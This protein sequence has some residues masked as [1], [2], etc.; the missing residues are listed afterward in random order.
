[1]Q[2]PGAEEKMSTTVTPQ[3]EQFTLDTAHTSVEFVVRHLMISKVRGRFTDPA[4]TIDVPAGSDLPESLQV[5]IDAAG[6]DTREPQRDD[7]LR[8]ADFFDTAKYP[9]I[10]YSSNRIEG[11]PQAFKVYGDLT[12]HG[13]TRE[14]VLEGSFE[15]RARDPWGND[16]I[17]YTA[18]ANL[19]RK[20]F[21]LNWNQALETGGV[22]VGEEVRI[23]LNVEAIK[24]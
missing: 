2:G 21:G 1:M 9:Q 19:N 8:S 24:Q 11:T 23:E 6:I 15:G 4:G 12:I 7:H 22:I 18:H 3:T 20:D 17:G 13:V 14:V 10:T 16:R 5:A